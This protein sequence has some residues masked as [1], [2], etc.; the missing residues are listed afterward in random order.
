MHVCLA[1]HQDFAQS[2]AGQEVPPNS[3]SPPC[4]QWSRVQVVL[5]CHE[6][7]AACMHS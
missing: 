6:E 7:S 2:L 3:L 4:S 1:G 5:P